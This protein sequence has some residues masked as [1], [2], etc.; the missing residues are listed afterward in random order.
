[1]RSPG[2]SLP[3]TAALAILLALLVVACGARTQLDAPMRDSGFDAGIDSGQPS[4]I[5]PIDLT[6]T[7][8][9]SPATVFPPYVPLVPPDEPASCGSGFELGD[10][11]A[12]S[13]YTID[14]NIVGGASAITLDVDFATYKE[15]DAI[16]ITGVTASGSTYTLMD[17]CRLQTSAVG[18]QTGGMYR[19]AD[20]TI[21]QFRLNLEAGTISLA[22]NFSGV[23][24]PMYLQ[25]LGLCDFNV[26]PFA[27]AVWWQAVP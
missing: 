17:S 6:C 22:F 3:G 23:V 26:T 13:I 18:D 20:Q 11:T 2:S 5:L 16:I 14:S 9:G 10:A 7:M 15:P 21:R 19:P 1:V 24:S 4:G 12:G 25:V 8:G 27:F